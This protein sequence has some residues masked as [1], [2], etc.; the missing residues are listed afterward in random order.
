L[1]ALPLLPTTGLHVF[2][3]ENKA[4]HT[5]YSTLARSGQVLWETLWSS[6]RRVSHLHLVKQQEKHRAR[7]G[8]TRPKHHFFRKN[9]SWCIERSWERKSRSLSVPTS[10]S[11]FS[12][13]FKLHTDQICRYLPMVPCQSA[14]QLG[15]SI[16]LCT[17]HTLN[18]GN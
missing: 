9:R 10:P 11:Y 15:V 3:Q 18:R 1:R 13:S 14:G 6:H 7:L 8:R 16:G 17:S 4:L 5:S 12:C 2:L